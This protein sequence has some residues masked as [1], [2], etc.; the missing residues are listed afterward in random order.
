MPSFGVQNGRFVVVKEEADI[1]AHTHSPHPPLPPTPAQHTPGASQLKPSLIVKLKLP[2]QRAQPSKVAKLHIRPSNIVGV[3][4][5]SNAE[6]TA[7]QIRA[8]IEL[9]ER[10]N[11]ELA[12]ERAAAAAAQPQQSASPAKPPPQRTLPPPMSPA[13]KRQSKRK[14]AKKSKAA[15]TQQDAAPTRPEM[16]APAASPAQ[17]STAST[18]A[19]HRSSTPLELHPTP[20][21][22]APHARTPVAPNIQSEAQALGVG[23]FELQQAQQSHDA[24]TI[25]A[26]L[27]LMAMSRGAPPGYGSFNPLAHQQQQQQQYPV[28]AAPTM[29]APHASTAPSAGPRAVVVQGA[30]EPQQQQG[31]MAQPTAVPTTTTTTTTIAAAN[32]AA[33]AAAAPV[34]TTT[35]APGP[36]TTP[37]ETKDAFVARFGRLNAGQEEK[38][39]EQAEWDEQVEKGKKEFEERYPGADEELMRWREEKRPS[40]WRYE[41]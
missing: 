28:P 13:R 32:T 15:S 10:H 30:S 24:E 34:P 23:A 20:T 36:S 17:S 21:P 8:R 12:R 16:A 37:A 26:A 39:R 2:T 38:E 9:L 27:I 3:A 4:N 41:G 14:G 5:P 7:R 29:P 18:A 40:G 35:T 19:G 33:A 31:N 6:P 1:N 25:E 11:V 22:N